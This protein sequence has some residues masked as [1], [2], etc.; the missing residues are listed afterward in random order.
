MLT[1]QTLAGGEVVSSSEVITR[2][3]ITRTEPPLEAAM[4]T[5]DVVKTYF[6]TYTYFSTEVDDRGSETV[7]TQVVTS[8]DVVTDKFYLTSKRTTQPIKA[9]ERPPAVVTSQKVVPTASPPEKQ[10]FVFATKTYLTTF[11]YFTTLLQD[12]GKDKTSTI[13][14]SRTKVV[15]NIVTE[16]IPPSLLGAEYLDAL[17]SSFRMESTTNRPIVAMA[18]LSGGQEVKITAMEEDMMQQIQATAVGTNPTAT[19][20][21]TVNI[22]S[23]M[24][25][26]GST[27]NVENIVTGSTI[28]FFDDEDQIDSSTQ[29]PGTEAKP[30]PTLDATIPALN[31]DLILTSVINT[32][33]ATVI[34]PQTTTDSNQQV[35][36]S[37][38]VADDM[39]ENTAVATAANDEAVETLTVTTLLPTSTLPLESPAA[40]DKPEAATKRPG[41]VVGPGGNEIQVSDLLSLGS[42]GINGLNALGPVFNAMAGLIQGN[43][44]QQDSNRRNDTGISGVTYVTPSPRIPQQ[45]YPRPVYVPSRQPEKSTQDR[46]PIYIPVG[47]IAADYNR[48]VSGD[49]EI[50]ESQ[51]YEGHIHL[52]GN[53]EDVKWVSTDDDV[54]T[55]VSE[56]FPDAHRRTSAET[57]VVLGRPTMEKP[58]LGD[59]IPISPGEVITANS[60]VI[61]GKPAV[62]GPR[63]PKLSNEAD[64]IPIG[65]RPPPIPS[66][67]KWI[68]NIPHNKDEFI[69][70]PPPL[71]PQPPRDNRPNH[72]NRPNGEQHYRIHEKLPS[73][74]REQHLPGKRPQI[75]IAPHRTSVMT[76]SQTVLLAETGGSDIIQGNPIPNLPHHERIPIIH[77]ADHTS[78][79]VNIQ[80]SQVAKVIIPHGS[81]TAHVFSAPAPPLSDNEFYD[82]S[83]FP[84]PEVAP[85]FVGLG[86]LPQLG[87]VD[88]T[89]HGVGTVIEVHAGDSGPS[90]ET[91]SSDIGGNSDINVNIA[92]G[93]GIKVDVSSGHHENH[94]IQPSGIV[95]D[96]P[97]NPDRLHENRRPPVSQYMTGN[98]VRPPSRPTNPA[99]HQRFPSK[100]HRPTQYMTPPS[101]PPPASFPRPHP[102]DLGN[103][104]RHE[105]KH[106]PII[107][108]LNGNN[109]PSQTIP[110]TDEFSIKP[111]KGNEDDLDHA[112]E[113]VNT[114]EEIIQASNSMPVFPGQKPGIQHQL[115]GQ[116]VFSVWSGD[117]LPTQQS[118]NHEPIK[119][120]ILPQYK[121]NFGSVH[122]LA[123]NVNRLQNSPNSKP[124]RPQTAVIQHGFH[125]IKEP[126]VTASH[127]P[128]KEQF[129]AHVHHSSPANE[130]EN[131]GNQN[132]DYVIVGHITPQVSV[133]DSRFKVVNNKNEGNTN[134]PILIG[135]NV[136]L[137]PKLEEILHHSS[138]NENN[139]N[140]VLTEKESTNII[141]SSQ[142]SKTKQEEQKI[143]HK[144]SDLYND[145]TNI[146]NLSPP[147]PKV[148]EFFHEQTFD[149]RE[150]VINPSLH[151]YKPNFENN[152]PF[153]INIGSP[154]E[155]SSELRPPVLNVPHFVDKKPINKNKPLSHVP[156]QVNDQSHG[157]IPNISHISVSL[158]DS[159]NKQ[160]IPGQL[161][162]IPFNKNERFPPKDP[163]LQRDKVPI[164]TFDLQTQGSSPSPFTIRPIIDDSVVGL[165]PPPPRVTIN[166]NGRF[167]TS[168]AE[169]KDSTHRPALPGGHRKPIPA[170]FPPPP[171]EFERPP[172]ST[173]TEKSHM[174]IPP[175]DG[176]IFHD[177]VTTAKTKL[178]SKDEIED[179]DDQVLAETSAGNKSP[180]NHGVDIVYTP[181]AYTTYHPRPVKP[182]TPKYPTT[183]R[184]TTKRITTQSNITTPKPIT[185]ST[186][187]SLSVIVGRPVIHNPPPPPPPPPPEIS[188]TPTKAVQKDSTNKGTI[189]DQ[190]WNIPNIIIGSEV[191]FESSSKDQNSVTIENTSRP[192]INVHYVVSGSKTVFNDVNIRPTKNQLFPSK[193]VEPN[194]FSQ[195]LTVVDGDNEDNNEELNKKTTDLGVASSNENQIIFGS[196]DDS[197][198][199]NAVIPTHYLTHTHT[200]TV[201]TT[202]TTVVSSEGHQPLTKTV[203]LTKTQTST[204][205]DTVTETQTLVRPTSVVQTV[206][207][208]VSTTI[209]QYPPG[210]PFDPE[211][212]PTFPTKL[213]ST[214]T[215]PSTQKPISELPLP[216]EAS[217]ND[218]P[219]EN[220]DPETFFVIVNDQ[221][222]KLPPLVT[223]PGSHLPPGIIE[224]ETGKDEEEGDNGPP[225]GGSPQTNVLLSA[226]VISPTSCRP[227]CIAAKNEV[228]Q[229]VE[230]H[231]RC[232]CRPGFAR[233]FLDRPCK[234]E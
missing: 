110:K 205:V 156:V 24:D 80:P 16:T 136:A 1:P 163:T 87:S 220:K 83:P 214:T 62:M 54:Q 102:P 152:S 4:S 68:Q 20:A 44:Y 125:E 162:G 74:L 103:K 119:P 218:K 192:T 61:I 204:V 177:T 113:D 5:T 66:A 22:V 143:I 75:Q 32:G 176:P 123:E 14:N 223:M 199:A 85:E 46:S 100:P 202:E 206:T 132:N 234:R 197:S 19:V 99:H 193:V 154:I 43:L 213:T 31:A 161:S 96:A 86:S 208:T 229:R 138:K 114:G 104:F 50:A 131:Q 189:T 23:S 48:P 64:D 190:L 45:E 231:M 91:P 107:I 217:T 13:V 76:G 57:N 40:T 111:V 159:I 30:T 55:E 82:P 144:P 228:C 178:I 71:P 53:P 28:I 158:E 167:P 37:A 219:Q 42:L 116:S 201:T 134:N 41:T 59:G 198:S 216:T 25:D 168:S 39:P 8:T 129:P 128:T 63:P 2:L 56:N 191:N 211:N 121:P 35:T 36:S 29:A 184:T 38:E 84:L 139:P 78:L 172:P 147:P 6:A 95:L 224:Y 109:E 120:H 101:P 137:S 26:E 185:K 88:G 77:P 165:S 115:N 92:P 153:E 232:V 212:Y 90:I 47:G 207:T 21:P 133:D 3:V 175:I 65:M 98:H 149:S 188:P 196:N 94:R 130:K 106:H 34:F 210:S 215:V 146:E 180:I 127:Q 52:N 173:V 58:L 151:S 166:S 118:S 70:P 171:Y 186:P 179:E 194:G 33:S 145:R 105:I 18:T 164:L 227:D 195:I 174:K 150:P 170:Q 155:I 126:S 225:G 81:S 187:S 73:P 142:N 108:P 226:G 157:L 15:Q 200:L 12:G 122:E 11:T 17:R 160:H 112:E 221:Q 148:N 69:G 140:K 72:N 51:N 124:N 203:V 93:Q 27:T 117:R 97:L 222:Q 233:M 9:T 141:H 89:Q 230:G 79:L 182:L 169:S 10:F 7:H 135:E 60:D 209:A 49:I 181:P 67:Q 183:E